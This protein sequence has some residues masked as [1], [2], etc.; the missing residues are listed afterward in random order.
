MVEK[1][2]DD[3]SRGH[4][5]GYERDRNGLYYSGFAA[6]RLY[7]HVR[8]NCRRSDAQHDPQRKRNRRC[9]LGQPIAAT[10]AAFG[11]LI[12]PLSIRRLLRGTFRCGGRKSSTMVSTQ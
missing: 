11:L 9:C 5:R 4:E 3:Q 8:K 1:R 6:I 12:E 7:A 2:D 10:V